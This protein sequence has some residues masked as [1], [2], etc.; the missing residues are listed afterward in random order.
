MKGKEEH[1]PPLLTSKDFYPPEDKRVLSSNII[2]SKG[3]D[4]Y[5]EFLNDFFEAF[6][7]DLFDGTNLQ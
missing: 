6:E 7:D 3:K 5:S 2:G 4:E 1:L